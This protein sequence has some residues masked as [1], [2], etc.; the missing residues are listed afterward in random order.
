[1]NYLNTSGD[2]INQTAK[3]KFPDTNPIA[4]SESSKETTRK[5]RQYYGAVQAVRNYANGNVLKLK[6]GIRRFH[7]PE[8]SSV[9]TTDYNGELVNSQRTNKMQRNVPFV[10]TSYLWNI[11]PTAQ[12]NV[13]A[14]FSATTYKTNS[15]YRSTN[16]LIDNRIHEDVYAP[17]LGMYFMKDFSDKS[18]LSVSFDG[19]IAKYITDYSGSVLSHQNLLAQD[20]KLSAEWRYS[21]N[22]GWMMQLTG[23]MP[24]TLMKINH[25]RTA[26]DVYPELSLFASGRINSIHSVSLYLS[27][28]SNPRILTSLN[29]VDRIDTEFEGTAGNSSLKT[30]PV[31]DASASYTWLHSNKFQLGFAAN[32]QHR[33]NDCVYDYFYHDGVI[34]NRL[35]NSGNFDK[36]ELRLSGS[37]KLFSSQL[38]ISPQVSLQKV[39]HTGIYNVDFWQPYASLSAT[40][41]PSDSFYMMFNASTPGGKVYYDSRGGY[42]KIHS[43]LVSLRAGYIYRNISASV[44][45]YPLY[46]YSYDTDFMQSNVVDMRGASWRKAGQHRI[47][48]SVKYTFG[49][50]KKVSKDKLYIE[51]MSTTSVR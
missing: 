40:F 27:G 25:D 46:K 15:L 45:V 14:G 21:F 4:M 26:N 38:A 48:I 12:L 50:G 6:A 33:T 28:T 5:Q 11:T 41:M 9:G 13:K 30:T 31:Y 24:V 18:Q 7:N 23:G 8:L 42:S 49:F 32:Y 29:D 37:I 19:Q 3:Y 22:N 36:L 16:D 39:R 44:A 10:T 47:K 1:M 51:N 17:Q 35:V 34:F 43:A 20:Y 2:S